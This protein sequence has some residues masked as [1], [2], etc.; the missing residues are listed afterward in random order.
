MIKQL[1]ASIFLVQLVASQV[2]SPPVCTIEFSHELD[3]SV[4]FTTEKLEGNTYHIKSTGLN[5]NRNSGKTKSKSKN[6][7]KLVRDQ[8]V[9][10]PTVTFVCRSSYMVDFVF[11]GVDGLSFVHVNRK[12][13]V[14][15]LSSTGDVTQVIEVEV[16]LAR[17]ATGEYVFYSKENRN[18]KESYYI[19]AN[20]Q[21]PPTLLGQG[22]TLYGTYLD[23]DVGVLIPC[24]ST[25]P[26]LPI[27]LWKVDEANNNVAVAVD[28]ISVQFDRKYGFTILRDWRNQRSVTGRFACTARNEPNPVFA[29]VNDKPTSPPAPNGLTIHMLRTGVAEC[30][31]PIGTNVRF[32]TVDVNYD[33]GQVLVQ[34]FQQN[35]TC[36]HDYHD[37]EVGSTVGPDAAGAYSTQIIELSENTGHLYCFSEQ[38][39]V[40]HNQYFKA[41]DGNYYLFGET[42]QGQLLRVVFDPEPA[43]GQYVSG[44]QIGV[45]S[46]EAEGVFVG[47]PRLF[48]AKYRNGTVSRFGY[49][50]GHRDFYRG[51]V[52]K[53][54]VEIIA[55]D[56]YVQNGDLINLSR[57]INVVK[58][59][60]GHRQFQCASDECILQSQRCDHVVQC[61]DGKSDE[62]NCLSY[63]R[64][65]TDSEF[66][67]SSG[68]CVAKGA[69]CNG[70]VDCFDETDEKSCTDCGRGFFQ[71]SNGK[72]IVD[73][74]TCDGDDDCEDLSDE[75]PDVCINCNGDP[76]KFKCNTGGCI[77]SDRICDG[78][79][80]CEDGSD[81]STTAC[82]AYIPKITN[83]ADIYTFGAGEDHYLVCEVQVIHSSLSKFAPKVKWETDLRKKRRKPRGIKKILS[84]TPPQLTKKFNTTGKDIVFFTYPLP[85]FDEYDEGD[86]T[87]VA[88]NG[89]GEA[90]R[91]FTVLV[92]ECDTSTA[93]PWLPPPSVEKPQKPSFPSN[94]PNG[95][96]KMVCRTAGKFRDPENCA[97]FH[98]CLSVG[99]KFIHHKYN[100]GQGT[101]YCPVEERCGWEHDCPCEKAPEPPSPEYEYED[102]DY[103]DIHKKKQNT[104]NKQRNKNKNKNKSKIYSYLG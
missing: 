12:R 39:N 2:P 19:F 100:C 97:S 82:S 59:A 62:I 18:V 34:C 75:S 72:C 70:K 98:E 89:V 96:E 7:K 24:V 81:E 1:V 50:S 94:G 15:K 43:S 78:F 93:K 20:T 65:C 9:E 6:N 46:I 36:G 55:N 48:Y 57:A 14:S 31:G 4:E 95:G 64:N 45:G 85:D 44:S 16:P 23:Q 92:P 17:N 83:L 86:Y 53:D 22:R 67:C 87:C 91:T 80:N 56:Q 10:L 79:Q 58:R 60:C 102:E 25:H 101:V 74:Y 41:L 104:K 8:D 28:G 90:K 73:S 71:C 61:S 21:G 40:V 77:P 47:E 35:A 103:D 38:T 52:S 37:V 13:D 29:V 5:D 63:K 3:N 76:T 69:R 51:I 30:F 84:S 49:T 27:T 11:Q 26:G 88:Y 32:Y 42:S 68:Q 54:M 66:T 99:S 33:E